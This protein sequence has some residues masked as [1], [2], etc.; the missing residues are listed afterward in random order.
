[1]QPLVSTIEIARP[2]E[3]VFALA[4][5]PRRFA[6]WQHDVVSVRMLA[7]SRF[8]TTRRISGAE[9]TMIQQIIRNDP[10]RGWAAQGIDGPLRAHATITI[11]PVDHGTRSRVTFTLDFERH[12]L[13]KP[14]VPLVRRQAQKSA[15]TSYQNLKKLL[16]VTR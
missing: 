12:G 13:G 2:P 7:D 1:M 11:E 10:P 8:T 9:R 6:E 4:T 14:L 15:P 5:D 16:E 3:V